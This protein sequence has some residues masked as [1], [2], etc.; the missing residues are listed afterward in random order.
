MERGVAV[1]FG[2]GAGAALVT[3]DHG[4]L[5]LIDVELASDGAYAADLCLE[6][7]QPLTMNGR[8]VSSAGR[9]QSA[10]RHS[11][12]ARA[13]RHRASGRCRVS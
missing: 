5:E 4:S 8:S 1:L 12:R 6:P 13:P 9:A 3:P 2:D 10:S 7:G 11:R